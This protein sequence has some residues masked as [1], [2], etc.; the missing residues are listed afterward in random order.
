MRSQPLKGSELD[1]CLYTKKAAYGNLVVLI[2][3][4]NDMLLASR[5]SYELVGIHAAGRHED[6]AAGARYMREVLA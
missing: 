3:Y 6:A 2:L 5:N 4:L 1:H